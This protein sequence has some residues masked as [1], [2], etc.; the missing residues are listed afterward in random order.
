MQTNPLL[1]C[2][3]L[4]FNP[5]GD[6][7]GE[8]IVSALEKNTHLTE[9]DF[10]RC[11]IGDVTMKRFYTAISTIL[12][13]SPHAEIYS[14]NESQT[15]SKEPSLF[16]KK[17]EQAQKR[18]KFYYSRLEH[19]KQEVAESN[20]K[21]SHSHSVVSNFHHSP[22]S[23]AL[24]NLRFENNNISSLG[25]FYLSSALFLA[26]LHSLMPL[27]TLTLH[28]NKN[29]T[30]T[31]EEEDSTVTPTN[32]GSSHTSYPSSSIL[33]LPPLLGINSLSLLL[34]SSSCVV[35]VLDLGDCALGD[36]GVIALSS[37][38]SSSTSLN[39]LNLEKY[40]ILYI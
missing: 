1:S 2:L 19:M 27:T 39:S 6:S 12:Q 21:S 29:L 11:N 23:L 24:S 31:V 10:S 7:G 8:A 15:E 33:S 30:L 5:L 32:S 37:G 25:L 20:A 3:A 13:L 18:F 36:N 35:S 40:D 38:L 26:S 4:R 34:S 22:S 28:G 9:L 14:D 16:T 17:E